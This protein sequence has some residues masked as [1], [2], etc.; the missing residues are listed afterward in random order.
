M[1]ILLPSQMF[2]A[3]LAEARELAAD[4]IVVGTH[5]RTPLSRAVQTSVAARLIDL[6]RHSVLVLPLAR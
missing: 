2:M 3:I 1:K 6:S 4:V 5:A